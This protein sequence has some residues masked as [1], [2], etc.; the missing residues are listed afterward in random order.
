MLS[1]GQLTA[2]DNEEPSET[3]HARVAVPHEAGHYRL[4]A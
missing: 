1:H 4:C 3:V 2:M